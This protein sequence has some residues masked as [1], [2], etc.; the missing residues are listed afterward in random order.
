MAKLDLLKDPDNPAIGVTRAFRRLENYIAKAPK[1]GIADLY[2]G[3]EKSWA[4]F[5]GEHG[6]QQALDFCRAQ[7]MLS[8]RAYTLWIGEV[9][10]LR[11]LGQTAEA[12]E[13]AYNL[14]KIN[15]TAELY[16]E[17]AA[18]LQESGATVKEVETELTKAYEAR[19]GSLSVA[20]MLTRTKSLLSVRGER[21]ASQSIS[22]LTRI[23]DR[24]ATGTIDREQSEV[25]L[26]LAEGFMKRNKKGDRKAARLLLIE[27][28]ERGI[29]P[30]ARSLASALAGLCQQS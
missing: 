25:G 2:P 30:Y 8:P 11:D 15:A 12:L 13:A 10:A 16:E 19:G 28:G 7:L 5:Y 24:A 3:A 4:A 20:A 27:V 9:R 14:L 23:W 18:C 22:A 21:A 6:P 26:I 17:I 29:N 1:T